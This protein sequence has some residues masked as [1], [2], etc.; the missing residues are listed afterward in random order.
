VDRE[1]DWTY[2]GTSYGGWGVAVSNLSNSSVVYSAGVGC[3]ISFDLGMIER[4]GM[5]VHAFDPTPKSHD[6][7]RS[8][9]VPEQFRFH[10]VGIF[11]H[12]G[13]ET[14]FPPKNTSHVSDSNERIGPNQ[15][16]PVSLPVKRISTLMKELGH[17]TI[18]VLKMDIEGAEYPV[19]DDLFESNIMPAQLLIEFHHRIN[20]SRLDRT[21]RAV[22]KLTARGYRLFY[23]SD[24][25][26]EFSFVLA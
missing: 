25:G 21:K 12:D 19:L 4:F 20:R 23:M 16:E 24:L 17:S 3:D 8:Q 1:I 9:H 5:V 11:S 22:D 13:V 6:W 2:I 18:D 7:V 14:V 10:D 26:D 15:H